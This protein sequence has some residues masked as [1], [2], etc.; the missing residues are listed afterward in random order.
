MTQN[1]VIDRDKFFKALDGSKA[2]LTAYILAGRCVSFDDYRNK[3]GQLHGLATATD[4]FKDVVK[5]EEDDD[6]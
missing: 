4:H 3:T 1:V 5:T 6:E 2:E